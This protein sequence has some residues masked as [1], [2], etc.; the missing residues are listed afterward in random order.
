MKMTSI[1]F[2]GLLLTSTSTFAGNH[3]DVSCDASWKICLQSTSTDASNTLHYVGTLNI[4]EKSVRVDNDVNQAIVIQNQ[5]GNVVVKNNNGK[6]SEV[7][8]GKITEEINADEAKSALSRELELDAGF[9][10]NVAVKDG[11]NVTYCNQTALG[12]IYERY[13]YKTQ[14]KALAIT[15]DGK[16]VAELKSKEVIFPAISVRTSIIPCKK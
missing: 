15:K 12:F 4:E 1:L 13:T 14:D 11:Q 8:I 16:I 9:D 2:L 10:A 5:S 3:G 6:A 7:V